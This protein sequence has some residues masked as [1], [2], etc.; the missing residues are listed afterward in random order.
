MMRRLQSGITLHDPYARTIF[1]IPLCSVGTEAV[2]LW[3][4][5][6]TEVAMTAFSGNYS[7][8]EFLKKNGFRTNSLM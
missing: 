4:C 3:T 5:A 6:D 7:V 8:Q 1:T 2:L